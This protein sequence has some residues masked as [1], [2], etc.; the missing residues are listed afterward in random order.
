MQQQNRRV[1]L[2]RK[3]KREFY[4]NI[5]EI[6]FIHNIAFWETAKT[7]LTGKTMTKEKLTL[8]NKTMTQEKL[9]L[10]DKT[11]TQEKCSPEFR[12]NLALYV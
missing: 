11:M 5:N 9:T 8:I 7:F 6:D 3:P 2:L 4:G 1:S 12:I 10:I